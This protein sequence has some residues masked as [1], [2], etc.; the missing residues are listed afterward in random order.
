MASSAVLTADEIKVQDDEKTT[1]FVD[2]LSGTTLG[3]KG[4]LRRHTSQ[5]GVH[6]LRRLNRPMQTSTRDK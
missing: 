6:K 5:T 1:R 2:A 3:I 4:I